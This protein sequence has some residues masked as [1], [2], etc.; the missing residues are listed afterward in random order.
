MPHPHGLII[1]EISDNGNLLTGRCTA[2][3][4]TTGR[5]SYE[6]DSEIAQKQKPDNDG[7]KG[8]YDSRYIE[9]TPDPERVTPCTLEIKEK[10]KGIYEF[11]W[12]DDKGGSFFEG[13]GMDVDDRHIAVSCTNA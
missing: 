13:I 10:N 9:T 5:P 6:I 11:V 3:K 2:T 4:K 12:R 8:I 7:V 1:Y